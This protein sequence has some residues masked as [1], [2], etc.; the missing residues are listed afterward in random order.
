MN[1]FVMNYQCI[2]TISMEPYSRDGRHPAVTCG[3]ASLLLAFACFFLPRVAAHAAERPNIILFLVDDMGWAD[4]PVYGSTFYETPGMMRLAREGMKFTAAY[5]QPLCSPTRA[6]L[7]TGKDAAARLQM[8]QA[9]TGQSAKNPRVPET[10]RP[11]RI[12][13]WPESRAQLPLEE[14]T[15]AEA[16]REGGYQTW[17]LGKWHLG[18]AQQFGPQKQGFE[19]V[20]GAGGAGPGGSYFA[21][22]N[23]PFLPAGTNGE[24]VC[25]RLT[26]EALKLLDERDT[27]K[28]FFMYLAHFNVHSPYM[29][30]P[31]LVE[32]FKTKAVPKNPQRNPVMAAMIRSMD[33]SLSALLDK[34]D[35]LNLATNTVFLFLSDNGGVHWPN[36]ARGLEEMLPPTSNLPLRGGKCCFYEGGIRVPLLMRWPGRVKSGSTMDTP[37]HV[38]D[39]FPTALALA[40]LK[41]E[42]GQVLDGENLV[43]LLTGASGLKR[44]TLFGHFPRATTLAQTM[45]GS[46]VREGDFKMI[47]LWFAGQNGADA[48]E[49]Y[50]LKADVGEEKNLAAA[51]AEKVTAMNR[52]LEA[53]LAQTGA[54]RP[55]RNPNWNGQM[56]VPKAG[57]NETAE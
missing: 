42:A 33:D 35:A 44:D 56:T 26:A 7:L 3:L 32:H 5:A 50:D 25:E 1:E 34:L 6:T 38:A 9:I 52:K 20:I 36:R 24:Y 15:V 19:K 45:G 18:N 28:P 27:A 12:A 57:E 10:A 37:V 11:D 31:E 43:P 51:M 22:Y 39:F 40:G 2:K 49:L 54:L 46:W 47:R 4:S 30:K 16:L 29:A 55:K 14:R 23:V 17:H 8:H 48:Y 13:C 41:P 53:W 21:P